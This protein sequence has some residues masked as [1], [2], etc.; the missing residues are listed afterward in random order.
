MFVT[1][2]N[3]HPLHRGNPVSLRQ[4][5]IV[6]VYANTQARDDGTIEQVTFVFLPPHG[7]WEVQES[8]DQVMELVRAA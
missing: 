3:A 1:L 5:L 7:T 6:S 8:F 2:T 4:D